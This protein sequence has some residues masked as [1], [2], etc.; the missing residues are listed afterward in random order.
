M[1][2]LRLHWSKSSKCYSAFAGAYAE[3]LL[4]TRRDMAPHMVKMPIDAAASDNARPHMHMSLVLGALANFNRLIPHLQ[5]L[6][7]S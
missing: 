7:L 6:L 5:L 2:V 1:Y 3:S 4:D